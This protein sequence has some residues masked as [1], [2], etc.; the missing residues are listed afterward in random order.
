[1]QVLAVRSLLNPAAAGRPAAAL[2]G[3]SGAPGLPLELGQGGPRALGLLVDSVCKDSFVPRIKRGQHV[4]FRSFDFRCLSRVWASVHRLCSTL[5]LVLGRHLHVHLPAIAMDA[6]Q[7]TRASYSACLS[8]LLIA[9][10]LQAR[11]PHVPSGSRSAARTRPAPGRR[12]SL[13]ISL[14]D[15]L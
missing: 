1:M 8:S 12:L 6:V 13:A 7:H 15:L 11:L 3:P 4:E 5:S 9:P 10:P 14:H 2:L